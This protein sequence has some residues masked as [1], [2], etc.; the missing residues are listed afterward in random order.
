M[1]AQQPARA[2]LSPR[3]RRNYTTTRGTTGNGETHYLWRAVDDEGE[4]LESFV[5]KRWDRNAALKF[6]RKIMKRFGSPHVIV[7][8]EFR[9]HGAEMKVIGNAKKQETGRRLNNRGENF[10][11][12]F[13]FGAPPLL[14][15]QFQAKSCRRSC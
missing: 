8:D 15:R 6:L 2:P 7:T 4:V 9:S 14:T 11:Q 10:H 12:P 5:T 1:A 13:Q 3:Y